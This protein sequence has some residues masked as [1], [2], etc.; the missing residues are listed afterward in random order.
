MKYDEEQIKRFNQRINAVP[1]EVLLKKNDEQLAKNEQ[2]FTA[3]KRSLS[4]GKCSYCGNLL[5]HFSDKKPCL[6]WLLFEANGVKKKHLPLLFDIKSYHEIEAYLRWVA[7]TVAL[8][9]NINDLTVEKSDSKV[10]ETTIVYKNL[11]WSLSCSKGDMEGHKDKYYGKEP[12]YHI[13]IKKNGMVIVKYADFHIPFNDFDEFSFA[14]KDNK[15]DK[16]KGGHLHGAGMQTLFDNATLEEILDGMVK[17]DDESTAHFHMDTIVEADEGT[18]I[19][20]DDLADLMEE[21]NRTGVPLSKLM[22]NLKNVRVATF[23][24][25]GAGIPEIAKRTPK[26]R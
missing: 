3:L 10:F 6:H 25:P 12:H 23:I 19:S 20:G 5:T 16:L 4:E 22:R 9:R 15:L 17:A 7:N 11:E 1:M 13:Q 24:E 21:S 14:V 8:M 2:E 18:T 26:K